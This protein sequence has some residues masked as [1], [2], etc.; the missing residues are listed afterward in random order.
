[1]SV[2]IGHIQLKPVCVSAKDGD[3]SFINTEGGILFSFGLQASLSFGR[4]CVPIGFALEGCLPHGAEE[5]ASKVLV[6]FIASHWGSHGLSLD[7]Q[8]NF[9]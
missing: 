2:P 5:I 3:Y 7:S 1:M 8:A 9:A 4:E 6:N